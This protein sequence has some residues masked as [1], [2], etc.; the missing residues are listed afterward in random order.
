[1]YS[2]YMNNLGSRVKDLRIKKKLTQ[3]ALAKLVGVSQPTIRHIEE[4][5]IERPRRLAYIAKALDARE[6]ALLFGSPIENHSP[7]PILT[8]KE[9]AEIDYK[10]LT[11]D[12]WKRWIPH[13]SNFRNYNFGI[14]I[15]DENYGGLVKK[16]S[17]VVCNAHRNL[18]NGD[19]GI[20]LNKNAPTAIIRRYWQESDRFYLIDVRNQFPILDITD[21]K[22]E[23]TLLGIYTQLIGNIND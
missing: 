12:N 11:H 16:D 19:I 22:R 1:M 10:T 4:G 9:I 7:R 14:L 6:D 13:P 5:R 18:K 3:N 20:F 23:Y 2:C 8:L 15:E 21:N 17:V